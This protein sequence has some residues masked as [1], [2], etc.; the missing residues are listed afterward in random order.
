MGDTRSSQ[1]V[2]LNANG[3]HVWQ[4]PVL[5]LFLWEQTMQILRG[6]D[7][8]S[9]GEMSRFPAVFCGIHF[10]NAQRCFP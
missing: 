9:P 2:G 1:K 10:V 3:A 6:S 5:S 7:V 8:N 4:L